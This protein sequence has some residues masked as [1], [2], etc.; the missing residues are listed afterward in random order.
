MYNTREKYT[1]TTTKKG[2]K[3]SKWLKNSKEEVLLLLNDVRPFP[4]WYFQS[5]TSWQAI[6]I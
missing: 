3:N 5:T 1:S 2:N 4:L 6:T